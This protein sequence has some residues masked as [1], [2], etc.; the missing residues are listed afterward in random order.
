M[1][2]AKMH[3]IVPFSLG[4]DIIV[5]QCSPLKLKNMYGSLFPFITF[6]VIIYL[7]N[8]GYLELL[9]NLCAWSCTFCFKYQKPIIQL[10][11]FDTIRNIWNTYVYDEVLVFLKGRTLVSVNHHVLCHAVLKTVFTFF[12]LM[13]LD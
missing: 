7:G 6:L 12:P 10:R 9:K 3:R 1:N 4:S 11:L 5:D 2:Y 13:H 8:L